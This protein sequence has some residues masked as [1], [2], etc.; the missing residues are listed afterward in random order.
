MTAE[1]DRLTAA[2]DAAKTADDKAREARAAS[3]AIKIDAVGLKRLRN[4]DQKRIEAEAA[5]AVR[6]EMAR[7]AEDVLRR[8]MPLSLLAEDSPTWRANIETLIATE[9]LINTQ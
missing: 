3:S 1:R 4:L 9:L 7:S 2:L 8:R 6:D 5:L